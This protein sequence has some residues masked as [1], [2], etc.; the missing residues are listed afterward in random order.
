[1]SLV[2]Q[3]QRSETL[4]CADAEL[5]P[6]ASAWLQRPEDHEPG[7]RSLLLNILE[8]FL[9]CLT[10]FVLLLCELFLRT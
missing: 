2:L 5:N 6:I 3:T 10:I 7:A 4:A 9:P 1:M 8:T